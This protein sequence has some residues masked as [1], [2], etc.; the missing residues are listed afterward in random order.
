MQKRGRFDTVE[1]TEL[2]YRRAVSSCEGA[3]RI[4]RLDRVVSYGGSFRSLLFVG[5]FHFRFVVEILSGVGPDVE[6]RFL[7]QECLTS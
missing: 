7:E 6:E 2:R 4:A 1:R 3:E 5:L